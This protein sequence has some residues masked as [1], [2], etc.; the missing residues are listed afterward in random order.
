MILTSHL[1]GIEFSWMIVLHK[2]VRMSRPIS[3]AALSIS[4]VIPDVPTALPSF[5]FCKATLTHSLFWDGTLTG[6]FVYQVFFLPWEFFVQQLFIV[7]LL[8][9]VT[10]YISKLHFISFLFS[11]ILIIIYIYF[12]PLH[13]IYVI[14]CCEKR[15]N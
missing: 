2:S 9:F 15:I 13:W 3:P 14:L 4:A 5:I 1:E 12:Y 10:D 7:L 8:S 11:S 6:F